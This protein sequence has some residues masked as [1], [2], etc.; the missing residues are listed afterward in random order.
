MS[1]PSC[2]LDFWILNSFI[3]ASIRAHLAIDTYWS[4]YSTFPH[5]DMSF[6]SWIMKVQYLRDVAYA[7]DDL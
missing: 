6:D 3:P 5:A 2:A 1:T 4:W 7:Q